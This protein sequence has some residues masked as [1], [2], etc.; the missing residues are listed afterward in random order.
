[1]NYDIIILGGG[2]NGLVAAFYLARAGKKVLVLEARPIVGG[3]CVT[4]ELIPGYRFSTCANVLWGLRPKVYQDLGLEERGLKVDTRRFL[5]LLPGGRYLFSDRNTGAST[6]GDS[7]ATT[8][9]AIAQFSAKDAAFLPQ[10]QEF[11]NRLTRIFG[12]FLLRLPPTLEELRAAC[13]DAE[14][15][16]ALELILTTPVAELAERFFE[17]DLMRNIG[18]GADMGAGREAGSGLL[19]ALVTAMGAYS[20]TG[21]PVL[22][23]FIRGGMGHL[24]ELMKQAAVEHGAEVRTNTLVRRIV[25]ERGQAQGVE[26]ASGAVL[27][28]RIVV[29]NA[30]P[31]RTFLHLIAAADLDPAFRARVAALQTHAAAGLKLHCALSE[32][33]RYDVAGGLTE[34]QLREATVLFSPGA[35]Y[36]EAAWQAA[37][38]GELP[39]EPVVAAFLPSVYDPSLAPAGKFTWS[40]YVTWAPV[41]LKRGSWPERKAEMAENIFRVVERF[42]PNFRQAL[43]DYRLLTPDQFEKEHFLTDGNIHH[44][45][46]TA[47]QILWRRPLEELA[48]YRTPVAGLY[49]CGAGMHPWGEVSGAPGHNAAHTILDDLK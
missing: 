17:S 18:A 2:H 16:K 37:L 25:I 35:A 5:R 30:D 10:W 13:A 8:Q 19:L 12:P 42:S 22:N 29:S 20:E 46:A 39:T 33:P 44:V 31:K 11:L 27:R 26:L 3:A 48:H 32:L 41:Q 43:V 14:D 15:R 49:L 21:Q 23:G 34:T 4:E 1:M 40:A 9:K 47:S 7:L 45:D 36:Q 38:A 24:T 6:P 28:S